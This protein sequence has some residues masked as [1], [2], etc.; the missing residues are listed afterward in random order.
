MKI[1]LSHFRLTALVFASLAG[2]SALARAQ[3]AGWTNA[4]WRDSVW[5]SRGC[6]NDARGQ[7][8]RDAKFGAF[9]HFGLYSEL[10]G[11]WH[12]Q[13]PYDPAEQIMGLGQ[14]KAVI[15]WDQ[16]EKEVGGAFNPAKFNAQQWVGLIKKAGQKYVIVTAK[17]HDGFCMFRTAT[18][19]YNVVDSTPFA[20][21]VIKELADECKKQGIVFCV[22]YSI[23][24]WAAAN[25]M[26]P[27][28]TS[29]HDYMRAQLKEL[30]GNYG[31]IKMLWFD[32]YWY[33]NNQW[34]SDQAHATDLYAYIRSISPNTLVNDRVGRGNRSTDGDYATPENQLAGSRQSRYFEVV[35]TDT[36]DDNWGWVSTA[37]NYRRPADLIRNLIDCASKGG[38]FV[39]NVGPTAS[40]EFPPQHIAIID[41]I[42]Q[43]DLDQRRSHLR[44]GSRP[45]MFRGGDQQFP[46]LR[47]PECQEYFPSC[48]PLALPWRPRN[49]AHRP[50]RPAQAGNA[51]HILGQT[52]LHQCGR[53]QRH[54]PENQ[55]AGPDRSLRHRV[56]VDIPPVMFWI[57]RLAP[58]DYYYSVTAR[59]HIYEKDI[60]IRASRF[61]H[62]RLMFRRFRPGLQDRHRRFGQCP[63]LVLL[64][65]AGKDGLLQQGRG[66]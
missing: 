36:T 53:R 37:N 8:F 40:G 54:C 45:R 23:G 52:G 13:G 61:L 31:D 28:Y 57:A 26:A 35:M 42:W 12:G 17:H 18:T 27:A 60:R 66:V 10:G 24:D 2:L 51:G 22:Y 38:N 65:Q 59:I 3:E 46:M 32:N 55:T 41:A 1:I 62:V 5:E 34:T 44:H 50:N 16:Y 56:E 6:S 14:R 19:S 4:A 63:R 29:Y 48:H 49:C 64:I 30:L 47:H 58:F 25:V 11:Y 7:W 33:V 15:P 43:M 21:D 20:R 39:L 9:I